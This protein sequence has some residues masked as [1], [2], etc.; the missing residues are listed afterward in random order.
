M[1]YVVAQMYPILC[2]PMDYSSPGSSV[3]GDSPGKTTGVGCHAFL[4]GIFPT[5]GCKTQVSALQ[6]D[7]LPTEPPGK[8]ENTGAGSVYILQGIFPTQESNQ[9][10]LHC[11]RIL[12]QLSFERS[13]NSRY[14]ALQFY[15]THTYIH[16][17]THTHTHSHSGSLPL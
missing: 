5:Q 17:H 10:L 6:A 2:N 11:R 4:Q 16:T 12:Y 8:P 3:H 9:A 13:P 14:T 7:S 1:L 15:N